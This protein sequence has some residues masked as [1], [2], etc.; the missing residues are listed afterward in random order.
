V[1]PHKKK[2]YV[3]IQHTHQ[4]HT[5]S[6]QKRSLKKKI[7]TPNTHIRLSV[8]GA[9]L[10][11]PDVE[12]A[13]LNSEST[14][15]SNQSTSRDSKHTHTHTHTPHLHT[16]TAPESQLK[17]K[18]HTHTLA[19]A[20]TTP[21]HAPL[22]A[23]RSHTHTTH[24]PSNLRTPHTHTPHTHTHTRSMQRDPQSLSDS[25]HPPTTH[26][27]SQRFA[28]PTTTTDPFTPKSH[29]P[30][31]RPQTSIAPQKTHHI[32]KETHTEPKETCK[33][34]KGTQADAF[35]RRAVVG[36]TAVVVA[37]RTGGPQ[38][39]G[40]LSHSTLGRGGGGTV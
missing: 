11:N 33:V 21:T 1:E 39:F 35:R 30:S 20:H 15:R 12:I 24:R 28:S 37:P 22:P 10:L 13:H 16:S 31:Y 38:G 40:C 5:Q 9:S 26:L 25:T 23:A 18:K 3:Y 4:P 36:A 14:C 32:P 6:I 7:N 19:Y 29:E 34:S 27:H 17:V 8:S 2:I